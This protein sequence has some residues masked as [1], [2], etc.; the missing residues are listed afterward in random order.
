MCSTHGKS[1]E[2]VRKSRKSERAE[3]WTEDTFSS[4]I[5]SEQAASTSDT[6]VLFPTARMRDKKIA[7][8]AILA[9][10]VDGENGSRVSRYKAHRSIFS[11]LTAA[12]NSLSLVVERED[13]SI[14]WITGRA[15][16]CGCW[17]IKWIMIGAMLMVASDRSCMMHEENLPQ[18]AQ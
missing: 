4:Y 3:C 14:D 10:G 7:A 12:G 1:S 18:C 11:F 8:A 17:I 13:P 6:V 16:S 9:R 15:R 5:A 2:H